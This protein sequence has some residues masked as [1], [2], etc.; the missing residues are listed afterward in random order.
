MKLNNEVK[1]VDNFKNPLGFLIVSSLLSAIIYLIISAFNGDLSKKIDE[2]SE[3]DRQNSSM[4]LK[5]K[6]EEGLKFRQQSDEGGQ[7]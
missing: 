5:E 4:T 7:E 2:L 1:F 6:I 3:R